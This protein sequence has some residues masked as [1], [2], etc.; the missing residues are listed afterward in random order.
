VT[1][2][3]SNVVLDIVT[4]DAEWAGWSFY[5]LRSATLRGPAYINDIIYAELSVRFAAIEDCDRTLSRLALRRRAV[6]EAALF[7]AGKAFLRYRQRGGVQNCVL[8]DLFIGAQ[9]AVE[10]LTLLTRDPARYRS[11]FPQERL[12]HPSRGD[13]CLPCQILK[14]R[15]TGAWR[16]PFCWITPSSRIRSGLVEAGS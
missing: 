13:T 9:A 6:P 1:L 16:L 4:A 12:L 5:Q 3:D 10:N 11:H 8:S 7:L 14:H 2:I 15:A